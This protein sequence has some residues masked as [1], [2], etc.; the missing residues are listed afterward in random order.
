MKGNVNPVSS[1]FNAARAANPSATVKD[2]KCSRCLSDRSCHIES[3]NRTGLCT[4]EF[5]KLCDQFLHSE[6]KC[7]TKNSTSSDSVNNINQPSQ[8][9]FET[10]APPTPG[11][12]NLVDVDVYQKG[13]IKGQVQVL[14]DSGSVVDFMSTI[15]A[16]SLGLELSRVQNNDIN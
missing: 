4:H 10:S 9:V 2:R 3:V 13:S 11:T 7:H 1:S 8:D 15:L 16:Q 12:V 6:N 14:L 5:Y